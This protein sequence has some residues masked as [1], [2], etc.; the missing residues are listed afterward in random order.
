MMTDQTAFQATARGT[1]G[2]TFSEHFQGIDGAFNQ[3]GKR[4]ILSAK[5]AKCY[6]TDIAALRFIT[7]DLEH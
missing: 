3:D 4:S 7:K 6:F 1:I 5:K 2:K